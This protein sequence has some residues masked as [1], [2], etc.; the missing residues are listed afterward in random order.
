MKWGTVGTGSDESLG[1]AGVPSGHLRFIAQSGST[2]FED[3][4]HLLL[5]GFS[6]HGQQEEFA[7][8]GPYLTLCFP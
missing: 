7:A 6:P 3:S 2:C 1:T 5:G 8:H 4:R